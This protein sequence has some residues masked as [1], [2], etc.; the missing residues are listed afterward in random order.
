MN[1]FCAT[2]L[3]LSSNN[4]GIYVF[5]KYDSTINI[6]IKMQAE[7]RHNLIEFR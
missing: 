5:L 7:L 6:L 3:T 1:V 2:P 4:S